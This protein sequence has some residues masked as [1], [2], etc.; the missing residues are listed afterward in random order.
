MFIEN[1]EYET[2]LDRFKKILKEFKT[3]NRKELGNIIF[4]NPKKEK[5]L[6]T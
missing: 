5:D 1:V 6:K 3:L 4:K 2:L